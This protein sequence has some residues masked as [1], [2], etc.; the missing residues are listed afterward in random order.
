MTRNEAFN[1]LLSLLLKQV[2]RRTVRQEILNAAHDLES[3]A[4]TEVLEAHRRELRRDSGW[5][6]GR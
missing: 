2:P 4:V 1:R 6:A 3:A 5:R